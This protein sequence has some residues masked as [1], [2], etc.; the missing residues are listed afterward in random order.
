MEF[1]A[2][3]GSATQ[4]TGSL[5]RRIYLDVYES[6][7]HTIEA[8]DRLGLD[9]WTAELPA[10]K[11]SNIHLRL[12]GYQVDMEDV[13]LSS[14]Q[15]V[16]DYARESYGV[17]GKAEEST[18]ETAPGPAVDTAPQKNVPTPTGL[19]EGALYLDVTS[20]DE[21]RELML[22]LSYVRPYNNYYNFLQKK[23]MEVEIVLTDGESRTCYIRKG[24]LPEKYI[25]KMGAALAASP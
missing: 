20:R 1:P 3:A 8:L 21:I 9:G 11:V 16:I 6:M 12:F 22:Y 18:E 15:N 23:Y 10:E 25:M 13:D 17:Q 19:S 14:S 24:E 4:D 7:E 5:Y 2:E